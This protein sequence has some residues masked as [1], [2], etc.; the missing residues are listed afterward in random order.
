MTES[1]SAIPVKPLQP[2]RRMNW[3][4]LGG[5]LLPL[6]FAIIFPL[7]FTSATHAPAP[8]DLALTVV[9]PQQVVGQ[10][11]DSL[12]ATGSFAVTQTDVSA[13]AR[14][15]VEERRSV[16]AIEVTVQTESAD[17][18]GAPAPSASM[19]ASAAVQPSFAVTTYVADAGGRAEASAVESAAQQ[20]ASQLGVTATV[21]DVAPLAPEDP[22]G[23]NLFYLLVFSSLAGYMVVIVAGQVM[24]GSRLAV[25]YGIVG[26]AALLAPG[27][28]FGLSSIFVG[29]YGASIGTIAGVLGVGALYVLTVGAAAILVQQFLGS[30]AQFGVMALIVFLN[31]PSAGAAAP[32]SMLPPFWAGVHSVY[33]GSGAFEA[34]RSLTYFDGHGASRW[35]LQL[36]AWLVFF[37]AATVIVHLSQLVLKQRR[38]LAAGQQH[39]PAP[40]HQGGPGNHRAVDA[41]PE[42]HA[43]AV[44]SGSS[45][46]PAP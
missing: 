38:E 2:E 13:Q 6:F 32:A 44:A 34:F 11:A 7:A 26:A 4:L 16:G 28:V 14:A 31:F 3:R 45:T 35:I 18:S 8:H 23:T 39:R 1:P 17:S 46:V 27:I 9:G 21:V 36:L 43:I 20:I 37:L 19:D 40:P 22:L 5:L 33:F 12:D 15:S 30:Q 42:D 10:I 29:D 41:Q 25:R 24:P